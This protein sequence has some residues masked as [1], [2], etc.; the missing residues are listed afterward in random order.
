MGFEAKT[1]IST[2]YVCIYN[3]SQHQMIAGGTV[4]VIEFDVINFYKK[5]I[6]QYTY[7]DLRECS[8]CWEEK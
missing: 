3:S 8:F 5:H 2:F 7:K 1:N 6:M 4:T